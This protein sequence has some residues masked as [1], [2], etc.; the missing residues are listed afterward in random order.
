MNFFND[1]IPLV[2]DDTFPVD[3]PED[4]RM[5]MPEPLPVR[6]MTVED[7]TRVAGAGLESG[8]DAFYVDVLGFERDPREEIILYRADNFHLLFEVVEPPI[9]R[10][11]MRPLGIEVPNLLEAEHKL[12]DAEIE[13]LRQQGLLPGQET[14]LLQDPAGNWISLTASRQLW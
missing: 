11:D 9:S 14:L 7:V 6:L 1:P 8:L 10:D 13:Y 2:D 4:R 12:I 5:R 3:P